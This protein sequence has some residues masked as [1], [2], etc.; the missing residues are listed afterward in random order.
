MKKGFCLK[1]DVHVCSES[2]EQQKIKEKAHVQL[3]LLQLP[4]KRNLNRSLTLRNFS[5][6]QKGIMMFPLAILVI[7]I[8]NNYLLDW[9][10]V[11]YQRGA[12][13]KGVV[14]ILLCL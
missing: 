4:G 6:C 10:L 2:K 9:V 1:I 8:V 7:R 14:F 13:S 12:D 3:Q 5:G 11:R